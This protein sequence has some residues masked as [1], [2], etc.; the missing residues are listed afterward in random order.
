MVH[1][2]NHKVFSNARGER[3]ITLFIAECDLRS[4]TIKY[5][6]A[7][8]NAP[9]LTTG[10]SARELT[11]GGIGLGMMPALPFL[12]SGTAELPRGCT[13]LC[14]T[15]GLVEQEDAHE[16]PF[17]TAHL[18]AALRD[19]SSTGALAVNTAITGKFEAHRSGRPYLDDIALLTC[20]FK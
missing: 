4:R 15:D 19:F 3:F 7:G 10:S 17:G 20:K 11:E 13:L 1:D 5:V 16:E 6:N 8:H 9:I 12:K 14:Y 2:L 18:L